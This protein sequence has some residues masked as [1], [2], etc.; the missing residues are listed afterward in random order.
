ML[1]N[2][3]RIKTAGR[4]RYLLHHSPNQCGLAAPGTA[5]QQHFTLHFTRVSSGNVRRT[6]RCGRR[7]SMILVS[8]R[9]EDTSRLFLDAAE[10]MILAFGSCQPWRQ[11]L[12]PKC[13]ASPGR[14]L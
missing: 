12:F 7:P 6:T 11:S 8:F 1:A 10:A 4:L 5:S 14:V 3:F 9:N 2:F 13:S